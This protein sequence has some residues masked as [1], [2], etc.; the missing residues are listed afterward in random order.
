MDFL[1]IIN[2]F[3]AK[4]MF[5]K[6]LLADN[7][8]KLWPFIAILYAAITHFFFLLMAAYSNFI[9]GHNFLLGM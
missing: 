1:M 3:A 5:E 9:S 2:L 6:A 4:C 8:L 7:N